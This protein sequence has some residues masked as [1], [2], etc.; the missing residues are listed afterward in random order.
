MGRE[1]GGRIWLG[2]REESGEVIIGTEDGVIKVRSVRRKA[3]HEERG[4]MIQI[5]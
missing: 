3:T 4:N 1:M 5:A 2:I